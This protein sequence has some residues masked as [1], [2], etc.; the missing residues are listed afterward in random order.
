MITGIGV[1]D[2]PDS[3]FTINWNG[4]SR[5]TGFGVHNP[6]ERAPQRTDGSLWIHSFAHGRTTYDLKYNAATVEETIRKADRAETVNTF[7]RLLLLADVPPDEDQRLRELVCELSGSGPGKTEAATG[8]GRAPTR[9]GR[10]DGSTST[11]PRAA[12]R[13]AVASTDANPQRDPRRVD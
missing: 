11:N 9:S 1:H 6:P 8:P 12:S 3:A 4:C 2:P 5:S 10:T 7:E 13:R